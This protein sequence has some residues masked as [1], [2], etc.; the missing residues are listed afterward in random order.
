MFFVDET[1]Q[2]RDV[3]YFCVCIGVSLQF[4]QAP[5]CRCL[6]TRIAEPVFA[7]H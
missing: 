4:L 6:G 3:E 2:Q 1:C 5:F 7:E